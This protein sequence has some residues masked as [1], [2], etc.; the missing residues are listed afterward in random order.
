MAGLRTVA[1]EQTTSGLGTV[2]LVTGPEELLNDRV[3][4]AVRDAVVG[5][6]ADADVTDA[7][8]SELGA[9]SLGELTAPSLFATTRLVVLRQLEDAPEEVHEGLLGY[10][11]DP[12]PETALVLVHSG[13]PKGSGLL[14]RLR[15]LPSVTERR[16]EAVKGSGFVQF[17]QTEARRLGCRLDTSSAE[18]LVDAVGADLR[19]VAAAVDQLC[20]DFPDA[21]VTVEVV[22][23]Y[24]TGRADVKGY[25]I[26]DHALAGRTTTALEELRWALDT[27]VSPPAITGSFASA[28]RSLARFASA[29]R[30]RRDADLAKEVGVP[31]WKLRTLREQARGWDEAGLASA[32]RAVA[33][34]DG[35]VKGAGVDAAYALERMVLQVAGARGTR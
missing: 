29:P 12:D 1:R 34:A 20:H 30:A 28:V 27:G 26:A 35:Q 18:V 7:V 17:A 3:V 8:G 16:S 10:A 23:R 21:P 24:F 13:G 32:V 11:A 15:K 2:T 25:V 14:T 6:H 5:A 22:R 33:H 19:A 9:G 31:P 4:R